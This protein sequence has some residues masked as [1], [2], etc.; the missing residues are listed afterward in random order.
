[1]EEPEEGEGNTGS[2]EFL[3]GWIQAS[4]KKLEVL[5]NGLHAA[6]VFY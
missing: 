3:R 6:A 2:N 4:S 5:R 1:M